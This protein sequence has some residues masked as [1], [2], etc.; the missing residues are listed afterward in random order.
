M[1][2]QN[3]QCAHCGEDANEHGLIRFYEWNGVEHAFCSYRCQF[4]WR[5]SQFAE[6]EDRRLAAFGNRP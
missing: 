6:A 4:F 5:N 1:S 2:E 3:H